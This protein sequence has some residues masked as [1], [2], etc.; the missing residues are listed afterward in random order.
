MVETINII[1]K[2][3]KM[4]RTILLVSTLSFLLV[5]GCTIKR[6]KPDTEFIS[7]VTV[8]MTPEMIK[9]VRR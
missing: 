7:G 3:K 2:G 6:V 5:S 1:V 8:T 4:K 9:R